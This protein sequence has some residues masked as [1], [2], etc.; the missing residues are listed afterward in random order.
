MQVL[1]Y[2]GGGAPHLS[3]RY[4]VYVIA[5]YYR[6]YQRVIKLSSANMTLTPGTTNQVH[7]LEQT[8]QSGVIIAG[9]TM[10][11]TRTEG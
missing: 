7:E 8:K 1:H 9:A 5:T 11:G 4:H 10:Y 3:H 2:D 6:A